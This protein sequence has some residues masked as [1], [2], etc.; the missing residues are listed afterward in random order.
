MIRMEIKKKLNF[1]LEREREGER[2]REREFN[3]MNF[4]PNVTI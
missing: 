1:P 4:K 3:S 2:E